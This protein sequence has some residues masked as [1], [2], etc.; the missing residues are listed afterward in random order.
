MASSTT[1]L[2]FLS[3]SINGYLEHM[4]LLEH[5]INPV[6]YTLQLEIELA[7]KHGRG[8]F[9]GKNTILEIF[10]QSETRISSDL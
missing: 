2:N 8:Y 1:N 10:S 5:R 6:P 3:I 7:A 9:A 4:F